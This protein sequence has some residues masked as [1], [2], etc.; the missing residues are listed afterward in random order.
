MLIAPMALSK[1]KP[2]YIEFILKSHSL[3]FT[4]A[5]VITSTPKKYLDAGIFST[6]LQIDMKFGWA[7]FSL[8]YCIYRNELYNSW[9]SPFI[10]YGIILMNSRKYSCFLF[11]LD[12]DR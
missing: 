12:S 6:C 7:L 1:E 4:L 3:A 5:I 10:S 8:C 11:A 9:K 2:G